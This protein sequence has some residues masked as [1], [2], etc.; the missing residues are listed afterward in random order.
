M[1]TYLEVGKVASLA[2]EAWD[3]SVEDAALI[4]KSLLASAKS[5]EVVNSLGHYISIKAHLNTSKRFSTSSYVKVHSLGNICACCATAEQII[6]EAHLKLSV[7][8]Y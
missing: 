2:H 4:S 1:I 7:G 8:Y 5:F 3:N 6:K